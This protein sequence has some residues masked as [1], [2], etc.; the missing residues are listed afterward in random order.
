MSIRSANVAVGVAALSLVPL[1]A[2]CRP[3]PEPRPDATTGTVTARQ[4][5]GALDRATAD[6]RKARIANLSYDLFV[7]LTSSPDQFSGEATLRF[8]LAGPPADLR[9][10]FTGGTVDS[11]VVDGAAVEAES[12]GHFLTI[13]A[14][15]LRPGATEIRVAYTHPFSHDGTGLYRFVDPEDGRTYL[16][17]YLWPDSANHVFPSFDQ[18]NLK[19][20]FSLR[21][22]AP[23]GWTVVSAAP[24][25]AASHADGD[26]DGAVLWTFARTPKIA[27]YMFSLHAGPYRVWRADAG[28]L[29]LRLLARRSL[30]DFVA[31]DEWFEITRRGLDFYRHYFGVPYPFEKYDQILVPEATVGGMENVAAVTFGEQYVQRRESSRSQRQARAGVILHELAHMWFGD[32]VTHEWW[33][34]MWLSESF[35]TQMAA[36]AEVET[37]EFTDTWHGFFTDGEQRA[38]AR[39]SRVT[40]H[41]IEMTVDSPDDFY[42]VWDA[43]TYQKGAS[44]L[45]QLQHLVGAESYRRGV[46]A[47]LEENAWGNSELSD[48]IDHQEKS[49][50]LDLGEWTAEWLLEPGFDTL[51]AETQCEGGKLRSLVIRQSAP[52]AY[53][54]LR[55]HSIDVAL[56]GA[57]PGPGQIGALVVTDVLPVRVDGARTAVAVPDGQPCP[58]IVNPNF[59]DWT[60]AKVALS[61]AD[62]EVL[63]RKLGDV[64]DPLSRSIFLAA[65]FDR[66]K[67]GAMP[68]ADFVDQGL[69]LADGEQNVRV[70]QQ[71]AGSIAEAVDL[72]ERL[73]PETD[74]ALARLLPGI[75]ALALERARSGEARDRKLLWLNTFLDVVSTPAGLATARALLDGEEHI[76]GIDLSPAI[77][78]R[79]LIA[80]SR[81]GAAGMAGRLVVGQERDPSD[82]G[83]KS[84]LSAR[85]AMPVEA[86]KERW[87]AELRSPHSVRGLAGQR[88]VMSELFPASQT[89][90]QLRLLDEILGAL[91]E[92]S[93]ERDA[94]FLSSYT[95]ALLTP[96]CRPESVA[97]IEATLDTDGDRL[98]ATTLRFLREA[99]QADAECLAL[100]AAQ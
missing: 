38:F 25:T 95:Q 35:A 71:I 81:N 100:R 21:V 30:A 13:P 79:L 67:A 47:Y 97:K 52:A 49:S 32:L 26:G 46:S 41:P 14:E 27:T 6:R 48:F 51:A 34:G 75:E 70:L 19:A 12:N 80:L 4:A 84:L 39:D 29:P 62:V 3:V 1:V 17:S 61:A 43:I 94:Y 57:D 5:T 74:A 77:R 7:D 36:L 16:Y 90:L 72:M 10:D 69:R 11:V 23:E 91:P 22:R 68:L 99:H 28:D 93:R 87:L 18:P 31:V 54:T 89:D 20:P 9:V 42:T 55:T 58:V 59:N 66:A 33:D 15:D 92:L 65:L 24:G 37:T 64:A 73:R 53:P 63:G 76:A 60:Y 56:Y 85:A 8:D 88:A 40:T 44:V 45:R 96:M 86:V 98:D 2:A 83:K 50:G 82:F 78:W